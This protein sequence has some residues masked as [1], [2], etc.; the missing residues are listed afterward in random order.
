MTYMHETKK[1]KILFRQL[2]RV[3]KKMNTKYIQ[4]NYFHVEKMAYKIFLIIIAKCNSSNISYE[5]A[6]R[7][8]H[9][10]HILLS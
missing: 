8:K 9:E 10:L 3:K 1:R 5:K 4:N 6:S 2:H 7:K